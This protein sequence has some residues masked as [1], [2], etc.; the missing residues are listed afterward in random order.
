MT[1]PCGGV[2]VPSSGHHGALDAAKTTANFP[3][4]M[5]G[6]LAHV[7][8]EIQVAVRW[9]SWAYCIKMIMDR[10]PAVDTIINGIDRDPAPCFQAV[11]SCERALGDAGL[12]S[13]R[14]ESCQSFLWNANRSQN[15]TAPS[16]TGSTPPTGHWKSSSTW[17]TGRS[18]RHQTEH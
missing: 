18:Y 5:E 8:G 13:H 16:L 11:K 17:H 10:H 9:S 3:L 7:S 14:G 1:Q 15:R 6:P 12:E 4:S 2:C